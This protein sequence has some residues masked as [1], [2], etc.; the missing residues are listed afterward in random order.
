MLRTAQWGFARRQVALTQLGDLI[1]DGTSPYPW[2]WEYAYPADCV[3]FRYIVSP[4]PP[5]NTTVSPP[6]V[7]LPV[8]PPWWTGASRNNRFM[9]NGTVDAQNN[10]ITTVV[11]NVYQ[12][13]GVY[14]HDAQVVDT[15]DE[16]FINALVSL[17]AY[18][19]VIPLSG[20]NIKHEESA[21][22]AEV[23]DVTQARV[24]DG[25]EA[26]FKDDIPTDWMNARGVGSP[27]GYNPD[28]PN[29]G[30]P[31]PGWGSWFGGNDSINWGS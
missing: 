19:L 1:P 23:M 9:L 5:A 10:P 30:G 21:S 18:K 14:T 31:G 6:A 22:E 26:F 7:G 8:G 24:A 3:K 4:P 2:L 27:F 25:N 28:F 17:L 20:H 16:L 11:S 13:I 29:Q 15:F 12:A